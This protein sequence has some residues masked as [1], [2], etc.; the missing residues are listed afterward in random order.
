MQPSRRRSRIQ[1]D[2]ARAVEEDGVQERVGK[3]EIRRELGQG[4][5]SVVYLAYDAFYKAELAVKVYRPDHGTPGRVSSQFVAEAA[6]AGKLCHPHIVAILDAVTEDERSY[7]AMEYVP[8]GNLHRYTSP[9]RL[10]PV[11]DVIQI[12]FK[13]CGAL[14]YAF[15]AGVVH[16]D[17]KPANILVSDGTDVKVADFGAAFVYAELTTQ[18]NRVGS[19]SYI[20]PEQIRD[21]TL[22]H[23]SDMFS[24]GVVMYEM[25]SG[26]KPFRGDDAIDTM[27]RVLNTTPLPL[28][29]L[30]P[31]LPRELDAIIQRM[32]QKQPADRYTNWADLAL[33]IA[34]VGRLSVYDQSIPDSEKFTA[35]RQSPL[36]DA[37]TDAELW[38]LSRSAQW[39]RVHS[40]TALVSEGDAGDSL[41]ILG[42]GEAKV[43]FQG[44]LLDVLR[45]GE[46]FGEMA[47]IRGDTGRRQ[48]TVQTTTE[49]LV[50]EFPRS[51][52]DGLSLGCQLHLMRALLGSM[53]DRLAMSN[54]R[55]ARATAAS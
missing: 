50:A 24:L 3:Y 35:L 39:R 23:Q 2:K 40:N 12:G 28:P 31:E 16:R 1:S 41:Y 7:V 4:A 13:C 20:A 51:A 22:T 32:L 37:L 30:R 48:A 29:V 36:L 44:R 21:E 18:R 9:G 33:D 53:A 14:D 38:E 42:H 8:G 25:L 26:Y 19:P 17:I 11:S 55:L 6:L 52:L 47:Y 43:T 10:L 5:A 34:R 54:A 46:S 27:H 15:R 49:A 45:A